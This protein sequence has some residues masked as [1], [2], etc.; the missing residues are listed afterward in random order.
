MTN[1]YLE[2]IKPEIAVG[3]W[4]ARHGLTA[5]HYQEAFNDYVG[6]HGMQLVDVSG[7]G[8][9]T[10]LYAGLW[11]RPL[12]RRRGRRATASPPPSTRP[13][14]TSSPPRATARARERLRDAPAGRASLHLP[15]GRDRSPGWLA[16]A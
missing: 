2:N 11:V 9:A 5:E 12:R 6:N 1:L 7:Y 16:T 3:G 14:S 4:I 13:R 10:T 8:A 15:Q